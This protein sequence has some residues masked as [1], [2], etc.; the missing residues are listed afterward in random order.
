MPLPVP[1]RLIVLDCDGTLID[2]Q[3][4]IV[5]NMTA[6]FASMGLPPPDG[7]A[8][9]SL[10]GLSL[11]ATLRRLL[12]DG[13]EGDVARFVTAYRHQFTMQHETGAAPDPLYPQVTEI[14]Q[15]L[16]GAG[17]LLGV[18][19]RKS[20]RGLDAVLKGHNLLDIFVTRQTTDGHPGKPHPAMLLQ[21]MA[22]A[23]VGP[24]DTMM[25]G[26]TSFDMAMAV[27][28]GVYPVGVAWGYHA[29]TDLTAAGAAVVLQGFGD[30]P[31]LVRERWPAP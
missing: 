4:N 28:A 22:E 6:A 7:E 12:P 5:A 21:A 20:R 2:S 30:L 25:V 13:D 19:T 14:L 10:I 9:R 23:G 3:H 15:E 31:A 17:Y 26:D 1:L 16:D 29:V 24:E 27:N 8:I 11:E 18:A